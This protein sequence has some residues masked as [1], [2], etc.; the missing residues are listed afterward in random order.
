MSP[1]SLAWGAGRMPYGQ[2]VERER[3][4]REARRIADDRPGAGD[5]RPWVSRLLFEVIE[6]TPMLVDYWSFAGQFQDA[7]RERD[8]QEDLHD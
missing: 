6:A 8:R 7:A 3:S 2:A 4:V 1:V 5:P